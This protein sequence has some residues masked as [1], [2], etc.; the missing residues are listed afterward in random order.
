MA[1]LWRPPAADSTFPTVQHWGRLLDPGSRAAGVF[2][3]LCDS[4]ADPVVLHGD[5]H[6]DNVLRSGYDN[7]LAIDPKGV[8]GE[9]AYETGALMRNPF[10][11]LL[12]AG[13]P[14][15]VL[16]RRADQLAELLEL[17]VA[18]DSRL[19]LRAGRARGRLVGLDGED[20]SFWRAVARAARAALARR[21]VTG[22]RCTA[23]FAYPP[24]FQGG[25]IGL[26]AAGRV[27]SR[28]RT[29]RGRPRSRPMRRRTAP[30]RPARAGR[31]ARA[32]CHVSPPSVL[33]STLSIGPQPD[34]A[35]PCKRSR[36]GLRKRLRRHEVRDPGRHE[37]RARL[38]PSDRRALVV[39]VGAHPVAG[40]HLVAG[41]R[42]VD[43]GDPLQPLH[44]RHPVPAGD[45][46][47]AA[48]SRA[49]AAAARRC[50]R[51]RA[52]RRRAARPRRV[53]LRSYSC[54]TPPSTPRSRPGEHDLERVRPRARPRSS[55]GSSGTP[56]HS[57]V[58]I[59]SVQ[60][61]LAHRSRLQHARA[62][63][64]R[65]PSSPAPPPPRG[66]AGRRASGSAR[67]ST[68]PVDL[69]AAT[70]PGR[71]PGCRSAPAGSAGRPA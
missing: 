28:G 63:A 14:A 38:D 50:T 67:G 66:H 45:H 1:A 51:K 7:W 15:R 20:P 71:R 40:D 36:P 65:T 4:M 12:D 59:A 48:G 25:G 22:T 32:S 43:D 5:L 29:A 53:R 8:V 33:T 16:R 17:D 57:A 37:Q 70:S 24:T 2:F 55:S 44:A 34:Q 60:P 52:G 18:R 31:R 35:R 19:G 39:L 41:E 46:A 6:H 3:E 26:A 64:R 42:L 54:S 58:P 13:D 23:L 68:R 30:R 27:A 10:P 69:R 61:R 49:A 62:V 11:G 21:T 9:P 47:G 56:V